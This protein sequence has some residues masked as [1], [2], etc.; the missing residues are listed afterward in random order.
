[1]VC[2]AFEP[3]WAKWLNGQNGHFDGFDA[4]R[5]GPDQARPRGRIWSLGLGWLVISPLII[6]APPGARAV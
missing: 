4:V 5:S 3:F 2:D 1:M 6:R